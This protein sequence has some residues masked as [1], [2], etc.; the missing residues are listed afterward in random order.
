MGAT[1][2]AHREV[3]G[4]QPVGLDGESLM[5][6]PTAGSTNVTLRGPLFSKQISPT[7]R[8]Q[9]MTEAMPKFNKRITRRG[10]KVG[11]KRN[12]IPPGRE[13]NAGFGLLTLG[14]G[15]AM[16]WDSTTRHPRTTGKT[17]QRKNV[18]II[19]A[20]APRVLRSLAR[21]IVGEL[22]GS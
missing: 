11:R 8:R 18:A 5:P 10:R 2:G 22:G 6:A 9:I 20:M 13:W 16:K 17:W 1:E 3:W 12:P 4:R 19:K 14:R 7:I 21:K 15:V